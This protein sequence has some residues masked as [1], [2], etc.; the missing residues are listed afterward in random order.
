MEMIW[1]LQDRLHWPLITE[2]GEW[3]RWCRRNR[4]WESGGATA[5]AELVKR[6]ER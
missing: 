3:L 4:D 5:A 2:R 1:A 6:S